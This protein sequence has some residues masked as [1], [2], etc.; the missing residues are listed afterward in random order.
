MDNKI[1]AAVLMNEDLKAIE[2]W[3]HLWLV[4]FS[5]PKTKS[6]TLSKKISNTMLPPLFFFGSTIIEVQSHKHVGLWL[7]H[8]L[9]WATHIDFIENIS[10]KRINL[11]MPFK[12][13]FSRKTFENIYFV[14]IR[15]ILEYGNVVWIGANDS[16]LSRLNKIEIKALRITCGATNRSNINL[17]YKDTQWQS[18]DS[19]RKFHGLKMLFKMI[20]GLCPTYLSELLPRKVQE[21]HGFNLRNGNDYVLPKA[22]LSVFKIHLYQPF[23]FNGINF[24]GTFDMMNQ[25]FLFKRI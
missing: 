25:C 14:F 4:D 18:L 3:A 15:P 24:Q 16:Q 9:G 21:C 22:R 6:M 7:D 23:C 13:K 20:N 10:S 1:N 11:L 2:N 19:R 5:A 17:L 8:N 12:Y